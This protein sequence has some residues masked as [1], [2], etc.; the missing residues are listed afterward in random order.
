[1]PQPPATS[2]TTLASW[3][4]AIASA[5]EAAGFEAGPILERSGL[6]LPRLAAAPE[7]RVP[8]V[9]MTRL[10][11][12]VLLATGEPAFGLKVAGHAQPLHFHDLGVM[13]LAG[14]RPLDALLALVRYYR[15]ISDSVHVHLVSQPGLLGLSIRQ[16]P[17]MAVHPMALDAFAASQLRLMRLVGGDAMRAVRVCLS[18]P[19]PA[20]GGPWRRAFGVLPEFDS[21][22]T[23]LWYRRD[24]LEAPRP[25]A[26]DAWVR[27][28]ETGV[29]AYLAGLD[30][31][32]ADELGARVRQVL[33]AGLPAI[34]TLEEVARAMGV[35][36][37]SLRRGL[38]QGGPGFRAVRLALVMELA[39][40]LLHGTRLPVGEIAARLGYRDAGS[41]SKAF[42][43]HAGETPLRWRQRHQRTAAE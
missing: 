5:L 25:G 24:Q 29:Q 31:G 10:W 41:F 13:L 37:R 6:S 3:A 28:S 18:R 9:L 42:R 16:L 20:Q 38:D 12:N 11:G 21:R 43:D 32:A 15:L 33:R 8:T 17:Q 1:M 30:G 36:A 26:P 14:Q 22:D 27:Q 7:G 19:A 35:S 39:R 40:S 34:S 23:V 4:L 2:P